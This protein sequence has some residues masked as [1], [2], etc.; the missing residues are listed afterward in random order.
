[1]KGLRIRSRAMGLYQFPQLYDAV[2]IAS[3]KVNAIFFC[4]CCHS[5]LIPLPLTAFVFLCFSFFAST[6]QTTRRGKKG[7]GRE[8]VNLFI[9]GC[10]PGGAFPAGF[11]AGFCVN[12]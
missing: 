7:R 6:K 2:V 3:R 8:F 9:Y 1:M 4:S 12:P 10:C 5:I 11:V